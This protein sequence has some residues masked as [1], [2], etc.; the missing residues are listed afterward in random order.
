VTVE[1]DPYGSSVY[2]ALQV[3]G[4]MRRSRGLTV[5][6]AF[7]WSKLISNTNI[8]DSPIAT[9]NSTTPQNPYD[10]SAERSVSEVDIPF[11][12]VTSFTYDLP[13]GHGTM[14][15]SG[16]RSGLDKLIGGWEVN[17]IWVEQSGLP[18]VFA[19]PITGIANGRPNLVPNVNPVVQG[20]RSNSARVQQWF[21][22]AAFATPAPYTFGTVRR[23][24]SGV[25]GPGLQNVDASL[26]KSTS[27]EHLNVQFRAEFFNVTNTPH[28]S[29]PNTVLQ[30]AA[31]GTIG[32]TVIS[33]PQ[34]E[35]QF[36]LKLAF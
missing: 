15:G 14:F 35:L 1:N 9:N 5:L 7:T 24:F 10:L 11:S 23:T 3:K 29:L 2:H 16:V 21:N 22:T 17:S 8:S 12:F 18:L 28:F 19:A 4:V 27:V 6:T 33:P 13:F 32:S 34:R 26:I 30:S 36:G 31:F 25:R 20:S